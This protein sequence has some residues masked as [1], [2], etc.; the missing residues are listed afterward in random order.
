[1]SEPTRGQKP[2]SLTSQ[3]IAGLAAGEER[4]D[5]GCPGLRVRAG[6]SKVKVFFYRYRARDGALREIKLGEFGDVLTLAKAR[7]A[8]L[9][10]RVELGQGRDPQ[11][12][13]RRERAEAILA[14]K[15]QHQVAYTLRQ[16]VEQYIGEVLANQKRGGESA[17][18]LRQDLLTTKL[19][20]R[21]AASVTRR[22]LQDE[23]IRPKM[24][25]APRV[26]TMLLSR[27]RCAYAHALEQGRL[28]DGHVS[29]TIGIRGAPQVRRKRAFSDAELAVFL[30]WLPQSPYSQSVRDTMLQVLLTGARSGEVVAQMWRD[31]DLQRAIWRVLEVKNGEPYDV[32]LPRQAV[33][34]LRGRLN[35]D[36]VYVYPLTCPPEIV[37][38]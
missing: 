35:R 7:K 17:R 11:L 21:P 26:A 10:K 5:G 6:T 32:M 13:K 24:A 8:V 20:N 9:A 14:R 2:S 37:L 29:P 12:E 31:T 28:P 38:G 4:G 36:P 3:I 33:Q 34:L 23:V 22:E 19:G 15:T 1:M 25:E 18:M 16:M 27:V 30:A